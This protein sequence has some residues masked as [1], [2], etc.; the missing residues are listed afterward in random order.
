M[1]FGALSA[2]RLGI[3]NRV[4]PTVDAMPLAPRPPSPPESFV[5]RI[6][7]RNARDPARIAGT[8]EI[9]ASGTER[10]F[11]GLH[12]LRQILVASKRRAGTGEG[13]PP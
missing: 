5:V 11:K 4:A 9:V 7:H 6:Y 8:V 13:G 3:G 10:S 2:H 1:T 12:E